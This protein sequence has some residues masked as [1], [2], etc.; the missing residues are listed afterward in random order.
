MEF[1]ASAAAGCFFGV[2]VKLVGRL[3][4]LAELVP[5]L[6]ELVGWLD[7]VGRTRI[8]V[9]VSTWCNGFRRAVSFRFLV[10]LN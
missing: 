5:G 9:P 7:K 6:A 2:L 1:A 3:V 4:G 10:R 8:T